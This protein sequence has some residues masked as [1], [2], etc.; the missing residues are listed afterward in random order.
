MATLDLAPLDLL[1]V[2]RVSIDLYPNESGVGFDAPQSF[3]KSVGGSPTNVAVSAARLGLR[4][5]AVTAVGGDGFGQFVRARLAAHGVDTGYVQVVPSG[6][7]PLALVAL[8][9]PESPQIAFYRADPAP[10]T[11]LTADLLDDDTLRGSRTLWVSHAALARGSTADALSDWLDRRARVRYTVLDLD[12]RPALWAD[13][14]LARSRARQAIARCDV[15]VGNREECAMALGTTDPDRSAD[16][17]LEGG[18]ALAVVKV[19]A[20]GVLIATPQRRLKIATRAVDVVC[21]LG[22]GD[23]FGGA[24][25]YGLLAGWDLEQIGRTAC[26]AGAFVTGRLTCSDDM[27]TLEDLRWMAASDTTTERTRP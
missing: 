1:T 22:A 25:V 16:A 2:G 7:T 27:P 23:A 6:Q 14:A 15:V 9:P 13:L 5:A 24:L 19:G 21:G 10:D 12:F 8:A 17:L 26:D 18:V 4:T 11:A 3:V 20:D